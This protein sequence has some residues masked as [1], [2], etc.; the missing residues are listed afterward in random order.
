MCHHHINNFHSAMT[1]ERHSDPIRLVLHTAVDHFLGQGAGIGVVL[2]AESTTTCIKDPRIAPQERK[3]GFTRKSLVLENVKTVARVQMLAILH[4]LGLAKSVIKGRCSNTKV[5]DVT[6]VDV[7]GDS[8]W[9]VEK[10]NHHLKLGVE[11]LE[12]VASTNDRSM[13]G[14]I[15]VAVRKMSRRGVEVSIAV[16]Q[17]EDRSKKSQG[18][19]RWRGKEVA[20]RAKAAVGCKP[21]GTVEISMMRSIKTPW[22]RYAICTSEREK[23]GTEKPDQL[24]SLPL[25]LPRN[26]TP[27]S[28]DY[29]QIPLRQL[30]T[31]AEQD[32]R[33]R[34]RGHL[35]VTASLSQ[36]AA[37]PEFP[38]TEDMRW[39][40]CRGW[41][42]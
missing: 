42:R 5:D 39:C 37:L 29:R 26:R 21:L 32:I 34:R 4:A 2:R 9:V 3:Y 7:I 30:L 22:N 25:G 20:R 24:N 17:S 19:E 41:R 16:H 14:R 28:A 33:A 23:V 40:S 18:Q 11:S 12:E 27:G 36:I 6:N 31:V 13:I 10:V 8:R 1:E 35:T 15:V 38:S